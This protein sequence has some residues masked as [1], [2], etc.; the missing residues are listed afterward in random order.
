MQEMQVRSL[1]GEDS[2]E[3][4]MATHSSVLAW[5]IPW[6][7]EPGGLQSMGSQ[8]VRNDRVCKAKICVVPQTLQFRHHILMKCTGFFLIL[9]LHLIMHHFVMNLSSAHRCQENEEHCLTPGIQE[10]HQHFLWAPSLRTRVID[11]STVI[12]WDRRTEWACVENTMRERGSDKMWR[13]V[14]CVRV[15]P[16]CS[17]TVV[18]FHFNISPRTQ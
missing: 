5:R 13:F 15:Y 10:G 14:E 7:E 8:R 16:L 4:G 3:M 17:L 11:Q 12:P 1:V 6:T 9:S 18:S 2:L